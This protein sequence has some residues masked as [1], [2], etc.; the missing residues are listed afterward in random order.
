MVNLNR[1]PYNFEKKSRSFVSHLGKGD[2]LLPILLLEVAVTGGRTYQAYKRGGFVEARERGTEETLGAI[3]WLGGVNAF[4]KIGDAIGKKVLKLEHVDFEAGKD[5]IRD[6]LKNY[7]NLINKQNGKLTNAA[8]KIPQFSEKNL[9]AFKFTKIVS[10]IL[11]SNIIIGFIVPKLNQAITRKYQNSIDNSSTHNY[12]LMK[13]GEGIDE[14]TTKNSNKDTKNTSFKGLTM[15][16]LAN[17][18]ET[19]ARYKLLSTDIGVAG[20]RAVSARNEPERREVLFRDLSSIYFYMYCKN[21]LSSLL[22]Y[23]EDGRGTRLNTVSAKRLDV[24]LRYNLKDA[25]LDAEEFRNRALGKEVELPKNVKIRFEDEIKNNKAIDLYDFINVAGKETELAHR[26]K[27]MSLLQPKLDGKRVLSVAQVK[28]IYNNCWINNPIFLNKVYKE[29]TN[30]NSTNPL[31]FV[32]EKD[33][34][35]L[36]QEMVDYVN[37]I[38]KNAKGKKINL[39][40]LNKAQKGNF[41][42][43]TLNLGAGFAV[44]AYFLSTAIPKIQ[45]WLTQK[46]TGENKFPGVQTYDK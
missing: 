18:F 26:A 39:E 44:S 9:A 12:T 15:L 13:K 19:D 45:Y 42:K 27:M 17:S 16:S 31:K 25:S 41:I 11:L 35:K 4:N 3:F 22:N 38:V 10:S 5:A 21:N 6:P 40:S 33:L 43:N 37:D 34:L 7:L 29:Y 23:V 2:A 28:D 46:Q 30:K 24:H 8:K 32:A 36:K 1:I 14:F 20:G